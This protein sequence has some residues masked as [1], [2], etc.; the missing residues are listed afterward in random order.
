MNLTATKT[1]FALALLATAACA[2]PTEDQGDDASEKTGETSQALTCAPSIRAAAITKQITSVDEPTTLTV[3]LVTISPKPYSLKASSM[4][5]PAGLMLSSLKTTSC[6]D[7][8]TDWKCRHEGV[9]LAVGATSGT[10]QY[11]MSF[12]GVADAGSGCG[13]GGSQKVDFSLTTESWV[14]YTVDGSGLA[15]VG[16]FGD[17]SYAGWGVSV[18]EAG[19]WSFTGNL[20]ALNDQLSSVRVASGW[21]VTLYEH[22]NFTGRTM[23][24]TADSPFVGWT[25]NDVASAIKVERL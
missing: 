11:S 17:A 20:A 9:L 2:A 25:F 5:Y 13:N 22:A 1:L 23:V 15:P 8:G 24:L 21:K 3:E 7:M 14:E 6:A 19:A 4:T 16:L 12:T 18:H 10:G